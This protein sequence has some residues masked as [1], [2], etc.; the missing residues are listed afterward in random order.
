MIRSLLRAPAWESSFIWPNSVRCRIQLI[1]TRALPFAILRHLRRRREPTT[2]G[3]TAKPPKPVPY[4]VVGDYW[5][6][7]SSCEALVTTDTFSCDC[8]GVLPP[9]IVGPPHAIIPCMPN[10]FTDSLSG[11]T[12][13]SSNTALATINPTAGVAFYSYDLPFGTDTIAYTVGGCSVSISVYAG[14]CEGFVPTINQS[15]QVLLTPN[16]ATTDLY[17]QISNAAYSQVSIINTM[18]QTLITQSITSPQTRINVAALPPGVYYARF[19]GAGDT[20]VVRWVKE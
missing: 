4:H 2:C 17:I 16:P 10:L 6:F 15:A 19:A 3:M 1:P 11:G 5:V 7:I 8:H 20:R 12:W 18:G 9:A 14:F 13:T